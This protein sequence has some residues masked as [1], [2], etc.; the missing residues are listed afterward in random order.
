MVAR[1][2]PTGGG[3]DYVVTASGRQAPVYA[4]P[5]PPAKP[6][7]R[8]GS[9]QRQL[10]DLGRDIAEQALQEEGGGPSGAGG[11]PAVLDFRPGEPTGP[12]LLDLRKPAASNAS[13]LDFS[14]NQRGQSAS[15]PPPSA[16]VPVSIMLMLAWLLKVIHGSNKSEWQKELSI[17]M[18]KIATMKIS[19]R[20]AAEGI[21]LAVMAGCGAF[22]FALMS[23]K[24][25]DEDLVLTL[26][27]M[28]FVAGATCAVAEI[29]TV[30]KKRN[31]RS[32]GGRGGQSHSEQP[33]TVAREELV[34]SCSW[35][36]VAVCFVGSTSTTVLWTICAITSSDW[37]WGAGYLLLPIAF[38][39]WI[40]GVFLRPKDEGARLKILHL[41]FF[42]FGIGSEVAASAILFQAGGASTGSAAL[43]RIPFYLIAYWLLLKLRRKAAQLPPAEL[44]NF[45]CHTVLLS[46]VRAIAPM[47]FFM[48][49]AL[50]CM[51][52]GDGIGD[53]LCANTL[54]AAVF[55]SVYLAIITGGNGVAP[56]C[57][58][59]LDIRWI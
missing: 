20:H 23:T 31:M 27:L 45:L 2:E 16:G 36:Y 53:D 5:Q 29:Y 33:G 6:P 58:R 15:V 57:G 18:E 3:N 14:G 9:F 43:A 51:A 42:F 17:S 54:C 52:S 55:L 19:W 1:F 4:P 10:S 28:G 25:P 50:S 39:C 13:L 46:G 12:T 59:D 49:E 37:S 56:S 7:N 22:L 21:L 8:P 35:W 40:L 24:E 32:R 47:M 41:Q 30:T 34:E 48:F 11:Q 26:G 38:T 44:S